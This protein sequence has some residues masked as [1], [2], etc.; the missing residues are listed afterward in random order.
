LKKLA[1]LPDSKI[2]LSDAPE[3]LPSRV[4]IGRFYRP[5]KQLISLRVDADVLAWFRK[6]GPRYQTYI[7]EVLR[8]EADAHRGRE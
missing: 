1:R 7:N 8:R 2:D 4:E 5:R 3:G 6:R